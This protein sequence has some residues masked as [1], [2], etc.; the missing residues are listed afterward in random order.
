M[1]VPGVAADERLVG[2]DMTGEFISWRDSKS[3][4]NAVI[5]KPSRFLG[6][7][8]IPGDLVIAHPVLAIYYLAHREKP[9]I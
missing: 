6:Y 7:T 1:H 4:A 5:H 9:F 8:A 2:L 3:A